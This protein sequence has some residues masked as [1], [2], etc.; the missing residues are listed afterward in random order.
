LRALAGELALPVAWPDPASPVPQAMAA[1]DVVLVPSR[2][3]A[4][5]DEEGTPT[6]IIEAGAARLP[7]VSTRHA[8]IPEQVD[9]G[10]TGLLA[11]EHD[12][13]GLAEA[14]AALAKDPARRA[15]MGEAAHAKMAREYSLDAHRAALERV[16]ASVLG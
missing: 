13:A 8:G 6:V 15:A 1:A 14:L 2:T 11:N 10:A 16:Y 4:D 3:A 12:V 9:D 7:V 5:G